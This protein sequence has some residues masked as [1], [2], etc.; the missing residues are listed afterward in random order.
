V[1]FSGETTDGWKV[2]QIFHV[3]ETHGVPLEV[4]LDW[5]VD[6]NLVPDWAQFWEE[7]REKKWNPRTTRTK[8]V[9]AIGEVYGPDYRKK[10]EVRLEEFLEVF[11]KVE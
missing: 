3:V 5:V 7:S 6:N 2:V 10:W 1:T 4:V 11:E 8:V 9:N